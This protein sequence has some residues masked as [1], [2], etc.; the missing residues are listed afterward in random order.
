[1]VDW[2]GGLPEVL[3]HI[4]EFKLVQ[5]AQK[6]V[7]GS[8]IYGLLK[9]EMYRETIDYMDSTTEESIR[10]SAKN[11]QWERERKDREDQVRAWERSRSKL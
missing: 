6:G 9:Q 7:S 1:M 8:S 10:L 4:D 11:L 3:A 5:K 2:L